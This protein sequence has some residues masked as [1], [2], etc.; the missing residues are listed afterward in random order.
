M[1]IMR[2][3]NIKI[4][5]FK[6]RPRAKRAPWVL[7]HCP[8]SQRGLAVRFF[9][10]TGGISYLILFFAAFLFIAQTPLLI[11]AAHPDSPIAVP[12]RWLR[13]HFSHGSSLFI[14]GLVP[15]SITFILVYVIIVFDYIRHDASDKQKRDDA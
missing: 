15:L 5:G 9:T 3:L 6:G 8:E 14:Y 10:F 2:N 4:P 7:R 13:A 1:R 11:A 12:I